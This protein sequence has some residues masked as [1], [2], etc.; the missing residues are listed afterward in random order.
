MKALS[1]KQPWASLVATGIKN[2]ECRTWKTNYR[3]EILICS[4][5][6]DMEWEDG[7]ER[8]ILPGGIP[9]SPLLFMRLFFIAPAA[10]LFLT[11]YLSPER[12][13]TAAF[14]VPRDA[15]HHA[16]YRAME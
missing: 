11:L 7:G 5:K 15:V 14:P 1:I 8:L 16:N 12:E 3:G 2:I 10:I 9:F 6:G 4:S 13:R